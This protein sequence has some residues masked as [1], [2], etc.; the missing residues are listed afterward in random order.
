MKK[1]IIISL[2]VFICCGSSR[3]DCYRY[4]GIEKQ[5]STLCSPLGILAYINNTPENRPDL[6]SIAS[7][8]QLNSLL[9]SACENRKRRVEKCDR[10]P[11]LEK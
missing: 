8:E 11:S 6:F 1:I 5:D 3:E 4:E 2:L 9:L 7:K 10:L